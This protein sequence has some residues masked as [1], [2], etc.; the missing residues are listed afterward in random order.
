[1][2]LPD[3]VAEDSFSFLPAALGTEIGDP[4]V[5]TW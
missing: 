1:M 5:R 2:T 3:N 4:R